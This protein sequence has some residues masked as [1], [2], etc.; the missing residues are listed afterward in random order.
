MLRGEKEQPYFQELLKFLDTE[1]HRGKTIYPA[2]GNIFQALSSTPFEKVL[3]VI[4]G[5]DPYHGPLQA[6]G[7]CF[8]V[9]PEVPPPPSLVNIFKELHSDLG[10]SRPSHGCL[11]KWA[12]QGVLLLNAVL[13]VEAGKPGS[14]ANRGWE[15]FTDRI[16]HELNLRKEQLVFLLW[17]AYAQRKGAFI[18]RSRHLVLTAPH[19]SPF[20][21]DKGFFGCKHF[22]QAN[23]YLLE[24]GKGSIDWEL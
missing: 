24:H 18:D 16:V 1:R 19:P 6:H 10:I 17:G 12:S 15:Q 20:S 21:A 22:S 5:Q 14:H 7:L 23:T 4:L 13:T 11:E 8:S 9:Q 2:K 3:V